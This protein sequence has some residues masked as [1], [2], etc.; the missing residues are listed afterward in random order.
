MHHF[1]V[2][3]DGRPGQS[4]QV[5]KNGGSPLQV[6]ASQLSH[7]EGVHQHQ[8]LRKLILKPCVAPAQMFY[9]QRRHR[10]RQWLWGGVREVRAWPFPVDST[11]NFAVFASMTTTLLRRQE[12]WPSC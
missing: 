4:V 10:W 3:G 2:G 6:A 11:P 5:G 12:T 1:C 9:P 7:D 8:T